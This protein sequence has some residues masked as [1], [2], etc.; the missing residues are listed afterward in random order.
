MAASPNLRFINPP[1]MS[2][3]PGYTHVIEA[4]GPG[5]IVYIAGQ[6]GLTVEGK[7]AARPAIFAPKPPRRSKT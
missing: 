5:R 2:K 3:P 4:T 6:L 1:T 7:L